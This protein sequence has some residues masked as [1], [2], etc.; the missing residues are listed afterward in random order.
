VTAGLESSRARITGGGAFLALSVTL[1]LAAASCASISGPGSRDRFG[2]ASDRVRERL[3]RAVE[4]G[5]IAGAVSFLAAGER[6]ST[7]CAGWR[8]REARSPMLPDTIFRIASM[9]KPVTSVAVMMLAEE[10]RIGLQDPVGKFLPG[11][12][13]LKVLERGERDPAGGEDLFREVDAERQVT[14]HDLLTHTSGLVYGFSGR[15]RLSER[16]AGAGVSDG[17]VET[18]FPLGENVR[19]LAQ[20]PLLHQPGHAWT[21]GLSTEV[22]GRVVEVASGL[23]LDEFF[24]RRIFE[25]LG[26]EDT[27]FFLPEEKL[28]R[29]A[30]L[31]HLGKDGKVERTG[32]EPVRDGPRVYSAGYPYRGPRKY[33]SPGGGLSSTARDYGR[34]L[35]MLQNRGEFGGARLLRPETVELMTRNQIGAL[36]VPGGKHGTGF[37]Y[38]FAVTLEGEAGPAP[39][40]SYSWEGFFYTFFWVDPRNRIAGILLAQL[41]PPGDPGLHEEF[42]RIVYQAISP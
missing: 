16:Y 37:G 36:R 13:E 11:W 6:R 15:E 9:T 27:Q 20:L 34:F 19:R 1:T 33:F 38:G 28:P 26:M 24:R 40:G 22:L 8:D 3:Q 32:E 10:G 31:Y 35:E 2:E 41:C 5:W 39:P 17:L 21:Y 25:P 18:D 12:R 7:I 23:P 29:L 42:Q 14:I 4:E 30:A